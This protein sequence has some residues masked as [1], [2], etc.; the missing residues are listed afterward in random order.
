MH[1]ICITS[2]ARIQ[3]MIPLKKVQK[4]IHWCVEQNIVT[5]I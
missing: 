2:T 4:Q 1:S 5:V 3:N